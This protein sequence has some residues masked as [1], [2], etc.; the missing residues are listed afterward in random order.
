MM[1]DVRKRRENVLIS[2]KYTRFVSLVLDSWR[3]VQE[4]GQQ[5]QKF[6]LGWS[7]T[8]ETRRPLVDG[9]SSSDMGR[10][11]P[12]RSYNYDSGAL[13]NPT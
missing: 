4:A 5:T 1:R 9:L 10:G 13:L 11:F 12:L 3:V 6:P 8:T 7:H 2:Y